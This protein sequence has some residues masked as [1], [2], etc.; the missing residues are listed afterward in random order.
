M[1]TTRPRLMKQA[2]KLL[3]MDT[4]NKLNVRLFNIPWITFY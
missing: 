2:T 1:T 4:K 3:G